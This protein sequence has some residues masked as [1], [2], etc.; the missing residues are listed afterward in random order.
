MWGDYLFWAKLALV[1]SAICLLFS[2]ITKIGGFDVVG[3]PKGFAQLATMGLLFAA[4][5][6]LLRLISMKEGGRS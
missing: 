4:N 3:G 6:S 2:V 5:F 1:L